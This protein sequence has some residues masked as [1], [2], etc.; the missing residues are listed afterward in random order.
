MYPPMWG[1]YYWAVIHIMTMQHDHGLTKDASKMISMIIQ[2][3]PCPG[4]SKHAQEYLLKHPFPSDT[5]ALEWG[6]KFHNEV[7][8]RT[9]K[10]VMSIEDAKNAIK[11]MLL[12]FREGED[13]S[14]DESKNKNSRTLQIVMVIVIIVI[15]LLLAGYWYKKTKKRVDLGLAHQ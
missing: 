14:E 10:P 4:C 2:N 8:L 7:N 6:I 9:G 5:T 3:L 1:R 13:Q 11:D 15:P 12:S